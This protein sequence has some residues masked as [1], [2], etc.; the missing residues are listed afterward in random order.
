[1]TDQD[2]GM[3]VNIRAAHATT[4][5]LIGSPCV[6]ADDTT[7]S[8]SSSPVEPCTPYPTNDI[9]PI[10]FAAPLPRHV[11]AQLRWAAE[12]VRGSCPMFPYQ[13]GYHTWD[14]GTDPE[15]AHFLSYAMSP[16][17]FLNVPRELNES[18]QTRLYSLFTVS[19]GPLGISSNTDVPRIPCVRK[20]FK[21]EDIRLRPLAGVA[22]I[23][24]RLEEEDNASLAH[25]WFA[26]QPN[27]QTREFEH[28]K[29]TYIVVPREVVIPELSQVV[30]VRPMLGTPNVLDQAGHRVL[31]DLLGVFGSIENQQWVDGA[32]SQGHAGV[33]IVFH[34][35]SA[36]AQ[37]LVKCSY[38]YEHGY[39]FT[40]AV[41]SRCISLQ[42]WP[43]W[44]SLGNYRRYETFKE[45]LIFEEPCYVYGLDEPLTGEQLAAPFDSLFGPVLY[46]KVFLDPL[47]YPTHEGFV[48]FRERD[49]HI[50]ALRCGRVVVNAR[51]IRLILTTVPEFDHE[52][53]CH[54]LAKVGR[55]F[56]RHSQ[57]TAFFCNAC[58]FKV[59]DRRSLMR[60]IED[61]LLEVVQESHRV[62][63]YS[64][65]KASGQQAQEA[66]EQERDNKTQVCV[67]SIV[68]SPAK[69]Q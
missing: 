20:P 45:E 68:R 39:V 67:Q 10:G 44:Q 59:H 18:Q 53:C 29:I 19:Q 25:Q 24:Q 42:I 65:E 49:H 16:N 52:L 6:T 56:C 30:L 63:I 58:F 9:T 7:T 4:V 13:H 35:S 48:V 51:N 60:Q 12:D 14:D 1:M 47:G 21:K 31:S 38:I 28:D 22:A 8:A 26:Q 33:R 27:D 64:T 66:Q 5:S 23:N 2:S 61:P 40:G 57:C 41:G 69:N 17:P 36:V 32:S 50:A 11:A 55:V 43:Y 46:A 62:Y 15:I 3:T 37:L 54:C 34:S